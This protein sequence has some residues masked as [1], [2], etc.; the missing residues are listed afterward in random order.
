MTNYY[1]HLFLILLT[2]YGIAV[3]SF[4]QFRMNRA[5]I[6]LVGA[7]TLI[8]SGAISL[9]H[10]YDAIDMNTILLLFAMMIINGNLRIAGFFKLITIHIIKFAKTPKQL[11][12]LITFSAGL[13]S[14][15]FLNDTIVIVFTPLII[16][17]TISLKRNPV[18]Y[19]VAL[20]VSANIGSAATIIGN[21]QNMIIGIASG[22]PFAKYALY[23][24]VP[25]L[26]GLL[27][28]IVIISI[29]YKKEFYKTIFD[30][31]EIE[32]VKPYKPLFIK[33]IVASTLMIIAFF[34]GVSIPLA[35]LG[36]AS[37]LLI[38]RRLKPER[39]F[40]EID[41]SL[42]VFF[43]ALFIVTKSIDTSGIGKYLSM[44]IQPYLTKSIFSLAITSSILSNIVSNVPAVLLLK[45]VIQH[46]PNPEHAWLVLGMATTYAGNLT[47]IGSVANLIVAE[48]AR[49]H[50]IH[51]S[52][53]EYLK[54]GFIITILSL[55]AGIFWFNLIF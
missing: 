5:T 8:F 53:I 45:P 54:S 14:A 43:S 11:L 1:I 50:F 22:I 40:K 51:I 23:Q 29:I 36:G 7:S 44:T 47:L 15:I 10:A 13:L 3:G 2:L 33:S 24:I 27:I 28:V 38:T 31:I 30:K 52:F 9:Q 17:V 42:L 35:S 26:I 19:L 12:W 48:S 6:A 25:S 55:T 21:P 16:E 20:A 39:V 49:R 4:P 18:P 34:A 41:W 37:I 32:E 46:M